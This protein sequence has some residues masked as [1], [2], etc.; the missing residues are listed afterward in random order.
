MSD[1]LNQFYYVSDSNERD[2]VV[3]ILSDC[4]EQC[5]YLIMK[6]KYKINDNSF[7][8]LLNELTFFVFD[9]KSVIDIVVSGNHYDLFNLKFS[10]YKEMDAYYEIIRELKEDNMVILF[11]VKEMLPFSIFYKD[12]FKVPNNYQPF[13]VILIIGQDDENFFFIENPDIIV[14]SRTQFYENNKQ[15]GIIRKDLL[16]GLSKYYCRFATICINETKIK[17]FN[18]VDDAINRSISNFFKENVIEDGITYYYGINAFKKLINVCNEGNISLR[19][20]SPTNDRD[21]LAYFDWKIWCIKNRRKYMY[22][23]LLTQNC[24]EKL[25]E[26]LQNS[27]K[28]WETLYRIMVKKYEKNSFIIDKSYIPYFDLIID[29][30]VKII[31]YA[32]Q[33]MQAKQSI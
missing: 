12:D 22:N 5:S 11:T 6:N 16:K 18:Y 25:K 4:I 10:P 26:E 24:S 3:N 8:L 19:S 9:S 7:K 13:H 33:Y 1:Y 17:E 14:R 27:I 31:E 15:V 30:E 23:Y 20:I 2:P 29:A 21:M 32:K 28:H